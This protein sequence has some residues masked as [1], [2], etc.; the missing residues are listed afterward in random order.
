MDDITDFAV[1]ALTAWAARV[2]FASGVLYRLP[3]FNLCTCNV[4]GP[5]VP[6]YLAG[7]KRLVLY[8]VSVIT[9]GQRLDITLV[10]DLGGLHLGLVA[11]REP[12]PDV[13]ALAGYLVDEL[14]RLVEAVAAGTP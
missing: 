2:M 9:D 12:V 8:P 13:D 4:P 11:C 14:E 10:G 1:P 7:A 5:N 3:A 6:V